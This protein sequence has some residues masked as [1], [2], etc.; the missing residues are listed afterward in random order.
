VTREGLKGCSR[1]L[2]SPTVEIYIDCAEIY[3]GCTILRLS[4]HLLHVEVVLAQLDHD[5]Q[6]SNPVNQLLTSETLGPLFPSANTWSVSNPKPND[7]IL[8]F[9]GGVPRDPSVGC[10]SSNLCGLSAGPAVSTLS[11]AVSQEM[12]RKQ[13][14]HGHTHT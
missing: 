7:D 1:G 2:S 10:M 12:Q 3:Y 4:T 11:Q 13:I 9:E 6:E 5:A 8:A 14:E